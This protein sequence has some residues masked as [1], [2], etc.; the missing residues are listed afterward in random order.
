MG[1]CF[2]R[3]DTELQ[4]QLITEQKCHKCGHDFLSSIEYNRHIIACNKLNGDL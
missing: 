2:S 4:N 1:C 3:D